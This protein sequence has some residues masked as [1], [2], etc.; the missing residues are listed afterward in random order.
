MR[1]SEIPEGAR[2]MVPAEGEAP[3]LVSG[4]TYYLVALKDLVQ[5]LARCTFVYEG[6]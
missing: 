6:P 3:A 1:Y 2:Q 4:E 5:P